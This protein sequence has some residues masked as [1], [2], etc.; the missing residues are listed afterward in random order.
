MRRGTSTVPTWHLQSCLYL[1]NERCSPSVNILLRCQCYI[2]H[3]DVIKWKHFARYWPFLWK[4]TSHR[5]IPRTKANDANLW[6]FLWSA[7]ERQLSKKWRGSLL[8]TLPRSL[9]RHC[10]VIFPLSSKHTIERIIVKNMQMLI[11]YLVYLEYIQT[12][13]MCKPNSLVNKKLR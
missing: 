2:Y 12:I 13:N 6:C 7:F 5:W 8:E 3:D 11:K 1:C 10:N 9:W 4:F